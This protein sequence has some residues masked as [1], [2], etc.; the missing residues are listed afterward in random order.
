MT[1]KFTDVQKGIKKEPRKIL[2][3]GPP[4]IGKSTLT[5]STKNSLMIPTEDRVNHINCE[6]TPVMTSYKDIMDVFTALLNEKHTYKRIILDTLDW[7]EPLLH[8]HICKEKGFKSIID[9]H[10]KETAFHKGLKYHAV[11]GW[12]TFL[13]NCDVLREN[14]IDIILV[15]HS[16]IINISPPDTDSYDKYVMK[17]DKN[18]LAVVEEWA[19][20]IAFYDQ[21]KYVKKEDKTLAPKGKAIGTKN[22]VL[23]LSGNNPAMISGNS[24]GLSDIDV[25]LEHCQDIMEYLLTENKN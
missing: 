2:I 24:Y 1:F 5:G 15:S 23:Y 4:K 22:R 16:Q 20:I 9:D 6:K 14:G 21:E 12:K 7:F 13:Y 11:A 18:A 25:T 3:Y 8:E 10:N 17:I 19:D